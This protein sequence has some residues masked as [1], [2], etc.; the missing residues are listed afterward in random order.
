MNQALDHYEAYPRDKG[1]KR[2][3]DAVSALRPIR[4]AFGELRPSDIHPTLLRNYIAKRKATPRK[5]GKKVDGKPLNVGP[6]AISV[7]LAYLRAALKQGKKDKLIVG[8]LPDITLPKNAGVRRRKRFLTDAE[9]GKLLDALRSDDTDP[10]IKLA[11]TL[12]LMTAQRGIAIRSLKWEHVDFARQVVWFSQTDPDP[13]AN[14]MRPDMPLTPALR[15]L[16]EQAQEVAQSEWVIEWRAG[17]V[18]SIKKGFAALVKR[19]G[20]EDVTFHDL[21]R[22]VATQGLRRGHGFDMVAALLGDDV[23]VVRAHYAHVEPTMLASIM[24]TLEAPDDV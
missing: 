11:V 7:E 16:L 3:K 22:T 2:V 10:H 17:P 24:P 8:E 19:A 1:A 5:A 20:L 4:E 23:A 12:A 9:I 21:R 6:R 14:K 15:G 13:A 18:V